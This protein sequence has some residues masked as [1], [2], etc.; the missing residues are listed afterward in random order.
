MLQA[1]RKMRKFFAPPWAMRGLWRLRAGGVRRVV[2]QCRASFLR[3]PAPSFPNTLRRCHST[4]RGL[5]NSWAAISGFVCPPTAGPAT[6]TSCGVSSSSVA[7]VRLRTVAPV[8]R[9]SRRTRS[10][11]ASMPMSESIVC[12]T[13]SC[14]RASTRRC[15][16][17]SHSPNRR[18]ARASVAQV[19][20]CVSRSINFRQSRSAACPSA[21]IAASRPGDG[22]EGD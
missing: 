13:R 2:G 18:C 14:S 11:N 16:R 9:S 15:S 20:T 5:R 17:R 7:P 6:C 10:A 12:A 19:L 8:A 21:S 3:E 22:V 4:V 1:S